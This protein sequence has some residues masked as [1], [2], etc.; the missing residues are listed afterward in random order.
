MTSILKADTIQDT[1][2]NNIINENSNTITIGA[3]GDTTNIIG[4]LQNNG[5]AV[6][7]TT[8][9]FNLYN[10]SN[11]SIPNSTVTVIEWS[12]A[13]IDTASGADLTNNRWTVPSGYA[14]NY[15]LAGQVFGD[16]TD[17][18]GERGNPSITING[19]SRIEAKL[20]TGANGGSSTYLVSG[21]Y[22]LNV[23]DYVQLT[24]FQDSGA[25]Q[26]TDANQNCTYLVG[27]RLDDA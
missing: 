11:Q 9:V 1:D 12:N 26:N 14:G 13:A 17:T 18:A 8:A 6:G 3:S 22:N 21:I 7:L 23:G 20:R 10:S 2:G 16:F 4:T 5:A 24:L 15:Y 27:S 19:T 25:S